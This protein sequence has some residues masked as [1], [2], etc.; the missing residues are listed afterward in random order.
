MYQATLVMDLV[1]LEMGLVI[2]ATGLAFLFLGVVVLAAHVQLMFRRC[3]VHF[4]Y[5]PGA[6]PHSVNFLLLCKFSANVRHGSCAR[7]ISVHFRPVHVSHRF[8]KCS[9]HVPSVLHRCSIIVPLVFRRC[10][11]NVLHAFRMAPAPAHSVHDLFVD[12]GF[13][14]GRCRLY[15][16]SARASGNRQYL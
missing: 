8:P 1:I 14:L 7:P 9:V 13:V 15:L 12:F 10:S 4:P 2:L 3:S 16:R 5:G 6:R 11:V